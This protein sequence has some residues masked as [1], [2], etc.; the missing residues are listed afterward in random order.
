MRETFST[1]LYDPKREHSACGVGFITRKDSKPSHEVLRKGHE[2]LCAIPHRGGMSSTGVGDGAGIS[3]DLSS[4]L[5]SKLTGTRLESGRFGVGNFFMPERRESHERA[6]AVIEAALR[7]T[8][9]ETVLRRELPVDAQAI[10]PTSVPLQLPIVQWI[11]RIPEA[12]LDAG[13]DAA[14]HHTL[15]AIETIAYADEAL[16][17]LYPLSL[18]ARTQVL[19]G[20][21]NAW[22][23]VPYFADLSDP[24]HRVHTLFFHTRFSTNTDPHPSMA[25]PF[26]LM[27]HNG[28]L[29]TDKKNRLSEAA[30]AKAR[31][32]SIVRPP[33][34]SDSCR[35]DQTLNARVFEDDMEL[36]SAVV[37]MMPPA[38]E[39]DERLPAEVRDMLAYFSLYE[40][41]NDG[42]AA[43]IF[44]DGNIIGA[45]LDRLGL[46]PLR[47][48]ETHRYLAV[49]SE[50]GQ[51]S[52][53]EA[54]VIHRGRIEAGGM[55]FYD[56]SQQRLFRTE[57]G[58]RVLAEA[59]NY[60]PL[61]NDA[62]LPIA[63]LPEPDAAALARAQHY[64]GDLCRAGRY[65]GYTLNQES[66][67]FLM[68]PMLDTG[69][70][71]VSAMGYGTAINALSDNEGGV[72]KYFSQ[73][74][75]QVTNPPLDSLREADGMTLRIALG[76]KPHA[77]P[78][79]NRQIVL[80]SPILTM[81]D[82][83]RI[84]N[85]TDAPCLAVDMLYAPDFTNATAN[86]R[87][88]VDALDHLASQVA[89]F[90]QTNG[91]IAILS[92]RHLSSHRAPLPMTLAVS[93]VNQRLIEDGL[94]LRVSIIVESGQIASSH[95]VACALGFGAS[96]VYA[97]S[98]R[99]RAEEKYPD[100]P[101]P[102][103]RR[104]AKAAE[105]AL[106]KTMAKVGL[107][108]V[109][110][111]CGGEFFEPNFLDTNDPIF[112]RYFPN[113]LSPVGGVR[114][115]RIAQSV[116]DWHRR[117]AQ[118]SETADVPMLG[119]FKERAEGAGHSYGTTA[120]RGFVDLTEESL[121]IQ[122][123]T[124]AVR[125]SEPTEDDALRLLTL[126]QLE[127]AFGIQDDRYV[128]TSFDALTPAQING[129]QVTSG[130]R[131]F[132]RTMAS[133][134]AKRPAALRDVLAFPADVSFLTSASEFMREMMLFNRAGN[135]DFVIRGLTV[136]QRQQHQFILK[137]SGP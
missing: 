67:R 50:A 75:A 23:L 120:V 44:G 57:D 51:I 108:T 119:L 59:T 94:R 125:V 122:A 97:L 30:I 99:L 98:M 27:A 91:G 58:L 73:R 83:I 29:N 87:K 35:F 79:G 103:Y 65:V 7:N 39:N 34:Q 12:L 56:H 48:I 71:R 85:Q 64:D 47:T 134:R 126:N 40:E 32:R 31:R 52:F 112:R 36:V 3:V 24:D 130:Y 90:A 68:D 26:R 60:K 70:E 131:E 77:G 37:S 80:D 86:E 109:E 5:F 133:E 88:L 49:T 93:A 84:K 106:L 11:F 129:F 62:Q 137:L 95:H 21:L 81:R 127:D 82:I 53:P 20:R 9:L 33:G 117:A 89:E 22:E 121:Q 104:F 111:Y 42:P 101:V 63:T 102:A 128:N 6:I 10:E 96:A 46:R 43:L 72:A 8:G 136:E 16:L 2:A 124:P 114:F 132:S 18:S 110:S 15:L 107:C 105:K 25:Q 54:D 61:L 115:D 45:R 135:L 118:V 38:W 66:F 123:H 55:L 13:V 100:D 69:A 74:F 76:E 92:D 41:K 1:T 19:K 78:T 17:G 113:M 4:R 116:V 28:E 14:M